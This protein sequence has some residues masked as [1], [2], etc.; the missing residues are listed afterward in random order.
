MQK[1]SYMNRDLE[2]NIITSSVCHNAQSVN[3]LYNSNNDEYCKI[4]HQNIRGMRKNFDDFCVFLTQLGF[5][6]D[7]I[8]LTETHL[9]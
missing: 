6:F 3:K 4:I 1:L 8:I 2:K 5:K 7:V 9:T